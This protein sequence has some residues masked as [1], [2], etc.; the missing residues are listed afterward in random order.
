M[1]S[2]RSAL[3]ITQAVAAVVR[4]VGAA[5]WYRPSVRRV[6]AGM[7]LLVSFGLTTL[8]H[9]HVRERRAQF[10]QED[11]LLYVPPPQRIE[12]LAVGYREALADLL[13][14]RAVLLAGDPKQ[15]R[16]IVFLTRHLDA[17]S[18]LAP[19][20]L[21]PYQWGS[22]FII[23][24]RPTLDRDTVDRALAYSRRGL[25]Q[26]PEDP[27]LLF[28]TGMLLH[29]EVAS[30]EGYSEEERADARRESTELV[31]RAAAFGASP[32][33]RQLAATLLR[34]DGAA[35]ELELRF[36]EEQ[37]VQTSDPELRVTLQRRLEEL[38]QRDRATYL[39][40]LR[41]RFERER[42]ATLPYVPDVLYAVLRR[43]ATIETEH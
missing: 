10:P 41:E 32:L 27:D 20:F 25:A 2:R 42:M 7:A 14:I 38:G 4:S 15:G 22:V 26:Y 37:L 12:A 30:V 23:Y 34:E 3:E 6:I 8:T 17:I 36:V 1:A 11:D 40:G 35:T 39:L 18:T 28:S 33:V 9:G 13:W 43:D 29:R 19:R 5:S 16:D 21:R 24:S 31:R